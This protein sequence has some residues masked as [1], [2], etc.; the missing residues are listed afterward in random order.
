M[1]WS[2]TRHAAQ[3]QLYDGYYAERNGE[4]IDPRVAEHLLDCATCS[5][6]Y[7]AIARVLDDVRVEGVTEADAIFTAE[8]LRAQQQ[9][10]ARR[11]EHIARPARVISFPGQASART[12]VS[13][14]ARVAPRWI[15]AAA[16]AG[17][18]IGVAVG[19]SYEWE[20]HARPRQTFAATTSRLTPVATRGIG[21]AAIAEDDAFLSELDAAGE[22]PHL[23]ELVAYDA[24]T[25]HVRDA[26]D[27]R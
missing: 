14:T 20:S 23:R 7:A 4:P 19:A 2:L 3:Q 6:R 9:Q 5:R 22:R 12:L 16:A 17:L 25:P 10:I 18:F 13:R 8:R 21:A 26:R 24:L 15:A 1:R 11:L 27:S